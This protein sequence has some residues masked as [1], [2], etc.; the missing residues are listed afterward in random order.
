[1]VKFSDEMPTNPELRKNP[2]SILNIK[3]ISGEVVGWLNHVISF[4]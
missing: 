2:E 4:E 1:M 3:Q